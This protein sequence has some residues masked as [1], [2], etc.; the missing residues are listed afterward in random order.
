MK[1]PFRWLL[2]GAALVA[3]FLYLKD[4]GLFGEDKP[5]TTPYLEDDDRLQNGW[6]DS[7]WDAGDS[8]W[9][10][11]S[12]Y[13]SPVSESYGGQEAVFS[14]PDPALILD[15]PDVG[16][17]DD[18]EL[19]IDGSAYLFTMYTYTVTGSPSDEASYLAYRL[20]AEDR[21]LTLEYLFGDGT[22][23]EYAILGDE[24]LLGFLTTDHGQ[25]ALYL[26][27]SVEL[28]ST[29]SGSGSDSTFRGSFQNDSYGITV[30]P[31][32]TVP[33]TE[34]S[35]MICESCGGSG[36][37]AA[38]GGDGLADNSYYGEHD[39]FECTVC[40]IRGVCPVC[41]GTGMWVFD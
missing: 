28:D 27:D 33:D 10:A 23:S 15:R 26:S 35:A 6:D 11:D 32:E 9:D 5:Y 40:Y 16:V 25:W 13:S 30:S 29:P 14:V 22:Y 3:V 8:S 7:G 38:C 19:E 18:V 12:A 2:A 17:T 34:P 41:D 4:A 37:C 21:G 20:L 39:A 1:H 31:G 24:Y 36:L